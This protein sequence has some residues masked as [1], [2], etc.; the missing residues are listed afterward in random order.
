MPRLHTDS[1]TQNIFRSTFLGNCRQWCAY[2]LLNERKVTVSTDAGLNR[3]C[4]KI[5]CLWKCCVLPVGMSTAEKNSLCLYVLVFQY[6]MKMNRFSAYRCS[7]HA[8][9]HLGNEKRK[10][11]E[12][13]PPSE[14]DAERPGKYSPSEGGGGRRDRAG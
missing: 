7:V 9:A 13:C 6:V 2:A 10:R 12:K 11:P 5:S 1:K 8:A 4:R 14:D 3:M